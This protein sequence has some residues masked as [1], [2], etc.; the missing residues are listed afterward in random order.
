M[1]LNKVFALLQWSGV[2]CIV[3]PVYNLFM[4]GVL[5]SIDSYRDPSDVSRCRD[6]LI[7]WLP[8]QTEYQTSKW[9]C[10]CFYVHYI[11]KLGTGG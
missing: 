4:T 6:I 9:L 11:Q 10:G 5:K 2:T 1:V 3:N 7:Y 8:F